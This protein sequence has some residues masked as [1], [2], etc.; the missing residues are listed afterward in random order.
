VGA[1][2]A[3]LVAALVITLLVNSS[4]NHRLAETSKRLATNSRVDE[5][6][7]IALARQVRDPVAAA[8]ALLEALRLDPGADRLR[9]QARELIA[10]PARDVV[11]TGGASVVLG[12]S[13]ALTAGTGDATVWDLANHAELGSLPA[14]SATALRPDGRIAVLSQGTQLEVYDLGQGAPA[15]V[16]AFGAPASDLV[17]SP[18]G[19]LLMAHQQQGGIVLW[20]LRDPAAPRQAATWEQPPASLAAATVLD[21][22]TVLASSGDA[23]LSSWAGLAGGAITTVHQLSPGPLF[24]NGVQPDAAGARALVTGPSVNVGSP[25]VDLR[26]GRFVRSFQATDGVGLGAQLAATWTAT[27]DPKG[28]LV[29]AFDLTGRGYVFSSADGTAVAS[30]LGGHS[31]LVNKAQ[32]TDDGL[33][34]TASLDG[35]LRTWDPHAADINVSGSLD[36]ALCTTF[37]SRIDADSWQVAMGKKPFDPPCPVATRRAIAPAPLQVQSDILDSAGQ[38]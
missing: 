22:G 36:D 28:D 7:A 14:S 6:A 11:E 12:G 38:G 23:F 3:V 13:L 34:L 16:T 15:E 26:N 2:V 20:D 30:L 4:S 31:D 5:L 35:T 32:F 17:F 33:L 29:A 19:A 24:V 9:T 8:I 21:D 27:M 10:A 37:G 1:V 18:D 25:L